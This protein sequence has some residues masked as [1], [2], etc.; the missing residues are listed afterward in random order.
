[1]RTINLIIAFSI[2]GCGN[3]LRSR[4]VCKIT[5]KTQFDKTFEIC[6]KGQRQRTV[7]DDADDF[8]KQCR[9]TA[10]QTAQTCE[11]KVFSMDSQNTQD[12]EM[13]DGAKI[14]RHIKTCK[15]AGL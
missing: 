3:V 15:E 6:M 5:D 9:F 11:H 10:A 4:E 12:D 14:P 2:F 8:V 13:C 1:V 7:T